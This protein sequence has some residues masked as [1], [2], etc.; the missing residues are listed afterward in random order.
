MKPP[1]PIPEALQGK[2]L[3]L[4]IAA[5]HG[6]S[7]RRLGGPLFRSLDHN[8]WVPTDV[9]D[10][11]ELFV[12]ASQLVLPEGAAV[13]GIAAAWLHGADLAP[14]KP[15]PV[16]VLCDQTW[17]L[18]HRKVLRP[19]RAPLPAGDLTTAKGVLCTTPL[20]TAYDLARGPDLREAVVAIDA[21]LHKKLITTQGLAQ[22]AADR[23]WPDGARVGRVLE[24]ADGGAES[25]QE[26]RLRLVLVID[27]GLPRPETQLVVRDA[28]GRFVARLDMGYRLRRRV[29]LEYDGKHHAQPDQRLRDHRRHNR[30]LQA[31][32]PTLYYGADD[33]KFRRSTIIREVRAEAGL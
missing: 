29:G 21:L 13:A 9:E 27:G 23:H 24:L 11:I 10:S 31:G 6:V 25:P 8:L 33:L 5:E 12:A 4:A 30:L 32:W 19:H 26:S 22:F 15:E 7:R 3:T 17:R 2:P 14:L 18:G 1:T 16:D 28:R 20:R